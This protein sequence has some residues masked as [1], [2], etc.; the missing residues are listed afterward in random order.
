MFLTIELSSQMPS[1][2]YNSCTPNP[3]LKENETNFLAELFGDTTKDLM[4]ISTLLT[5]RTLQTFQ[6]AVISLSCL[7][8]SSKSFCFKDFCVGGLKCKLIFYND[9]IID[10][11][12]C[13][14]EW[15]NCIT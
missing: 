14:Q 7:I 1:V 9:K 4:S 5:L 11:E 12:N 13:N 6:K 2:V 10:Q 3:N 8:S 15:L